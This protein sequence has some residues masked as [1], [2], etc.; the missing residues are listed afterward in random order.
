MIIYIAFKPRKK[1]KYYWKEIK[2]N[3]SPQN[4]QKET[5]KIKAGSTIRSKIDKNLE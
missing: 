2:I 3:L 4:M 1:M 5:G